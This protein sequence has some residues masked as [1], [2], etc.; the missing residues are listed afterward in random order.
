MKINLSVERKKCN[1]CDL[2]VL[3]KYYHSDLRSLDRSGGYKAG[4]NK[5]VNRQNGL[6][7]GKKEKPKTARVPISR[8]WQLDFLKF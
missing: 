8:S 7:E 1:C 2:E 3:I 4:N 6:C 5:K